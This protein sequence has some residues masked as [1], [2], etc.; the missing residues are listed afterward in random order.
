MRNTECGQIF[1]GRRRREYLERLEP[2]LDAEGARRVSAMDG[3]ESIRDPASQL[4]EGPVAAI[5][6][7]ARS[8]IDCG[9]RPLLRYE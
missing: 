9:H 4:P 1:L 8:E 5:I 2:N 3:R 6:L 7:R